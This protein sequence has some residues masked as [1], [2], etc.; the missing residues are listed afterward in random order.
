MRKSEK[1]WV[2]HDHG[3]GF[4]KNDGGGMEDET[5]RQ[6]IKPWLCLRGSWKSRLLASLTTMFLGMLWDFFFS[7]ALQ[8][9]YR[10]AHY[11]VSPAGGVR[12]CNQNF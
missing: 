6:E 4:P 3:V 7:I 5:S 11:L 8:I 12:D 1:T 10:R 9:V 2:G